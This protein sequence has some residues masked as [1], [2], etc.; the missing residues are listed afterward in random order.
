[1]IKIIRI[2]SSQKDYLINSGHLQLVSGKYDGL[3]ICNKRHSKARAKTYYVINSMAR[4][5]Y[6][7]L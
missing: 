5:L 6:H 7:I 2:T 1:M 3:V 4:F